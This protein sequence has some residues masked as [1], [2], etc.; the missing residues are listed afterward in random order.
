MH[1]AGLSLLVLGLLAIATAYTALLANAFTH[2]AP[3]WLALGTSSVLTGMAVLGIAR[4]GRATPLLARALSVCCAS[5]AVG[6]VVPLL[7]P[8]PVAGDPL[9]LGLPR[10]TAILLVLA[11]LLPLVLLPIAYAVAFE[12]EVLSE[13]DLAD[14]RRD[15]EAR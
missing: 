7:L 10:P 4:R 2:T 9:L 14:L 12:R 15:G 11:G 6:L 13:G 1:R 8:P 3:W 5:V